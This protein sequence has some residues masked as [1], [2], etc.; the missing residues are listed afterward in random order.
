MSGLFA[1]DW[2][3]QPGLRAQVEEYQNAFSWGRKE[4]QVIWSANISGAM[5]DSGSSPT[6]VIRPGLA[7]GI[8]TASNLWTNYSPSATDG[9]Q[10]LRGFLAGPAL[11][12][13]DINGDNQ[14]KLA[15]VI[16]GG[17]V[18]AANVWNL[19]YLGRAH[20][21][22][23]F[24]FDDDHVGNSFGWRGVTAKTANYTVTAADN[25]TI[26][27]NQ[28]AAGAVTFTLP[29][30]ARGLRYRFF[31]EADQTLTITAATADTLVVFNDAAAD[32][33]AFSTSSEKVGGCFEVI[34][35]AD[36]TKWLVFVFLGAETQ[37]PV[38]ST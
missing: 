2:G 17:M 24:L 27:T 19:D 31:V 3:A 30:I 35:N 15:A 33:I 29:T 25:N 22:G 37:T 21:F 1:Y 28:G 26:F 4:L 5:R 14:A 6:S 32:S 36:A 20:C 9:S 23:R 34:A 7:L 12:M 18:K 16:V 8:I 11:R 38:I 13:V 10:V